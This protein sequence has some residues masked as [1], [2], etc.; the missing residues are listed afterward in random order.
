MAAPTPPRRSL[1][2][3]LRLALCAILVLVCGVAAAPGAPAKARSTYPEPQR[4]SGGT[5]VHDPSMIRAK[6]GYYYVFST[7][8]G[9]E[10]RRSKDRKNWTYVGSV[11]PGGATWASQFQGNGAVDLWAPDVSYHRGLY[12]LYYSVSSFGSN[13]SAIGL[14]TSP[15]AAPGTWTDRGLVFASHPDKDYNAID[16][17]LVLDRQG[18][19]W[20]SFGSFWTGIKM[21]Q[22][23]PA[24]GKPATADPRVYPLATR[25]DPPD[26]LEG[27]SIIRHGGYY[28]LFASFDFCCRNLDATYNVRVGRSRSLTG[29]YVD[30][31]GK[32]LLNG[33]G[34]TILARHGY[35]V[36]AGGQSFLRDR[37]KDVLVYHFY[38]YRDAGQPHLG[39]NEIVW[40]NGWPKLR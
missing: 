1:S 21:I 11:L 8:T 17:G 4:L 13:Q 9:I 12:W 10:I 20:L 26:A 7:H 38:D 31:S 3:I 35:V 14:A 22:L 16:P 27:A 19:W 23:D 36:G 29:P 34:T 24:T 30:R 5:L 40:R 28:Y 32:P 18:R 33:G 6:D 39:L 25:P 2:R 37:G 15:S